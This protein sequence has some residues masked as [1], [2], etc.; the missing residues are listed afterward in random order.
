MPL[1]MRRTVSSVL[2]TMSVLRESTLSDVKDS[3]YA[4]WRPREK[5]QAREFC[6]WSR[7]LSLQ[8][9][10]FKAGASHSPAACSQDG[11]KSLGAAGRAPG[12]IFVFAEGRAKSAR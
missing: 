10:G 12:K 3:G 7:D 6:L 8:P 4:Y 11:G 1:S 9:A 5:V 2:P